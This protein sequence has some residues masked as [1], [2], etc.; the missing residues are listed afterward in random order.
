MST[1]ENSGAPDI[2]A[3]ELDVRAIFA[4][5][6]AAY[7]LVRADAPRWTILA[8]SNEYCRITRQRREHLIGRGTFEAFAEGAGA[9]FTLT[10]PRS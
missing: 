6:P 3:P 7:L 9:V 5:A 1:T 8:V 10:L 4:A 2:G